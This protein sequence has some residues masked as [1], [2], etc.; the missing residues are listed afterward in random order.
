VF[1]VQPQGFSIGMAVA[2]PLASADAHGFRG[3]LLNGEPPVPRPSEF[4]PTAQKAADGVVQVEL[5]IVARLR[6]RAVGEVLQPS[7]HRFSAH[8]TSSHGAWL[9]GRSLRRIASLTEAI[10]FF[11]GRT[12]L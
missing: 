10:V 7:P 2:I 3:E 1:R 6:D 4:V 12:P 8:T 5:H 9:P 11:E